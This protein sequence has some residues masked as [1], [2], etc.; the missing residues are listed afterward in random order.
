MPTSRS[1]LS[2]RPLLLADAATCA[3]MGALLALAPEPIGQLT[4]IPVALLFYAGLGLFPIAAFMATVATRPTIRTAGVRLIILGNLGWVAGSVLLLLAG[5]IG[6]NALGT[7][8]ILAQALAVALL[9]GLEQGA[10]RRTA[11]ALKAG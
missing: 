11:Q 8:F 1:L 2:L 9:A 3:A 4:E 7:A 5:W 6:P 10:L